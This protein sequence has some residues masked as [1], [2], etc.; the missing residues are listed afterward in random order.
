MNERDIATT[1]LSYKTQDIQISWFFM[2]IIRWK[3]KSEDWQNFLECNYGT[4]E[5][6]FIEISRQIRTA[7]Y[8]S[9]SVIYIYSGIELWRFI[10]EKDLVLRE[11][12]HQERML[13]P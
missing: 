6:V 11:R 13:V 8:F 2:I 3:L 5:H 1:G 7:K 10:G 4:I 9:D 12:G